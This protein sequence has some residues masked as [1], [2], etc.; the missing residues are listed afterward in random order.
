LKLPLPRPALDK[1]ERLFGGLDSL[2]GN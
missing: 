2:T 1:L